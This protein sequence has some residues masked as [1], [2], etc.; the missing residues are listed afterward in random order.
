LRRHNQGICATHGDL[1]LVA[2]RQVDDGAIDI[3]RD[4]NRTRIDPNKRFGSGGLQIELGA[5]RFDDRGGRVNDRRLQHRSGR[6]AGPKIP[7]QQLETGPAC[8]VLEDPQGRMPGHGQPG[9]T[10]QFEFDPG[11][12][13]TGLESVPRSQPGV[14]RER[15][16]MLTARPEQLAGPG[17]LGDLGRP[18]PVGRAQF[19]SRHRQQHD[20]RGGGQ[21]GRPAL[22][23]RVN[24]P[25]AR[26]HRSDW[27]QQPVDGPS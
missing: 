26:C 16:G 11:I 17:H 25:G 5:Q 22:R 6:W 4:A 13:R 1:H 10:S 21:T 27:C 18:R 7:D 15:L 14:E 12:A 2:G 20:R 24:P 8:R 9:S 3:P 23:P 19:E